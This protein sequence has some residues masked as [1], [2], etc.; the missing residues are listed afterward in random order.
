MPG[1]T[2]AG[3]GRAL[4]A[5][6]PH[7]KNVLFERARR[8]AR[9]TKLSEAKHL[10]AARRAKSFAFAQD[11]NSP[12]AAQII[13]PARRPGAGGGLRPSMPRPRSLLPD[14]GWP[15]RGLRA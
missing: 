11:D 14:G 5:A 2:A 8:A 1:V 6:A 9:P 4:P 12:R 15:H 10:S 3:V 13:V 7:V